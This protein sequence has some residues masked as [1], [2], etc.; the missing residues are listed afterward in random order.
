MSVKDLLLTLCPR[1]GED[2]ANLI[3]DYKYQLE[4]S[5]RV[6]NIN[7]IVKGGFVEVEIFIEYMWRKKLK[8]RKKTAFAWRVIPYREIRAWENNIRHNLQLQLYDEGF[9]MTNPDWFENFNTEVFW[10][11]GICRF[12][13]N[14]YAV[15]DSQHDMLE[16]AK[17]AKVKICS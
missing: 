13:K 3:V 5:E 14:F 6:S 1:L 8:R 17:A 15:V 4:L 7:H 10:L 9:L 12:K 11:Q 16:F 2:V